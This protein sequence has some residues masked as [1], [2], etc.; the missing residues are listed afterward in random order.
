MISSRLI[1][2]K[3][4]FLYGLLLLIIALLVYFEAELAILIKDSE[5][6]ERTL[7][8]D[9]TNPITSMNPLDVSSSGSTYVFPLLYSYLAYPDEEG[10]FTPD[11]AFRW[12]IEEN[13]LV[14]RFFL[15][16]TARFHDG[17][18]V[19]VEDVKNSI[20]TNWENGRPGWV[21]NIEHIGKG[22]G[23]AIVVRLKKPDNNFFHKVGS[24]EIFSARQEREA[25]GSPVGSGPFRF[26]ERDEQEELSLRR[27]TNFMDLGPQL[28]GLYF[29]PSRI[30]TLSGTDSC[31]AK[32][33]WDSECPTRTFY[34][35]ANGLILFIL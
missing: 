11:L 6:P 7:R 31:W 34:F 28:N 22:P 17:R 4:S 26:V 10:I 16:P 33:M 21:E 24:T 14:Y 23:N 19:S 12:T 27:S 20:L 9:V 1:S 18:L 30:R 25:E 3:N 5:A 8:V 29:I 15:Y 2:K 32:R 35:P 13:G